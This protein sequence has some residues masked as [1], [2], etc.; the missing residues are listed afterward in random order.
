MFEQVYAEFQPRIYRYVTRLV[1]I[2][3]ADDV[4]QEVFVKV[5]QALPN[6]KNESQLST[7][8]YQ[9]A[10]N[11]ATDRFRSRA[12]QQDAATVYECDSSHSAIHSCE[13]SQSTPEDQIVRK[14]MSECIQSYVGV[15]KENYR[16]VLILSE[17]EGFKNN[18]IASILG[19]SLETVKI[20]LHRA[21]EKLRQELNA[22]CTFYRTDCNQ[23]ACEPIGPVKK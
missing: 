4:T 20:R 21:K 8:I 10:T 19:L 15:L 1:G 5:H 7:W 12:F 3:D 11:T 22:N 18:E 23:L 6:F 16:V 14:E 2:K 13:S 17:L 9:I